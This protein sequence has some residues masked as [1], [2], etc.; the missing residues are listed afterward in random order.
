M[1][2]QTISDWNQFRILVQLWFVLLTVRIWSGGYPW[3]YPHNDDGL[4]WIL[5]WT[6]F[7]QPRGTSGHVGLYES[8]MVEAAF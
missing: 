7:L 8:S 6:G 5:L 3:A 4:V 1:S 2:F